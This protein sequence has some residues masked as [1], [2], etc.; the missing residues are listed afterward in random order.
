MFGNVDT[1]PEYEEFLAL[2]GQKVTK[3]EPYLYEGSSRAYRRNLRL[4]T[5][6]RLEAVRGRIGHR[7]EP[8]WN[9]FYLHDLG[10]VRSIL[11]SSLS[12]LSFTRITHPLA[13]GSHEIMFHVST[14][15][16]YSK[17]DKQQIQRKRHI[18]N[19]VV[20][21]VFHDGTTPF[22][23]QCITSKY[24][25]VPDSTHLPP[26]PSPYSPSSFSLSSSSCRSIWWCKR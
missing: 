15:L 18:G 7:E 9:P 17:K 3:L 2:L 14:L 24:S 19:D 5:I 11:T 6:A 1:S 21:I 26:V 13:Y 20:L 12:P 25:Q 4:G 8:Y 16:P 10:Q 22:Q 23:P